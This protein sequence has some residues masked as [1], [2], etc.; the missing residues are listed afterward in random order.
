MKVVTAAEMRALDRATIERATP[1]LVLMERAGRGV[2]DAVL[3]RL[4]PPGGRRI[5]V[6]AGAGNNGGDGLVAARLLAEHGEHVTVYLATGRERLTP[7]A[8]T[9]LAAVCALGV[10]ARDLTTRDAL[11]EASARIA[12]ADAVVDAVFGTG[13]DRELTPHLREVV[14]AMNRC[15]G[16]R[17]AVDVPSGLHADT[18]EALG[19]VFEADL[20]VTFA[21]PKI[22]L[23]THPGFAHAGRVETVDIGI[24]ASLA[25]EQGVRLELLDEAAASA[26]IPPRPLSGHK[27]AFGHILVV[28][29]SKGRTGAALLAGEGALRGG[30]GLCTIASTPAGQQALSA[31]VVEAMTATYCDD[32][33]PLAG[34]LAR[35]LEL[36]AAKEALVVGP[37]IPRGEGMRELVAGLVRESPAPLVLDADAL[38]L[39]VGRTGV[40]RQAR[41]PVALTPHPGEMARLVGRT[42]A[43]V[44]SDR[45]GVARRLAAETGATVALKGARTIIACADGRAWIC[46]TGNPGMASGGTGDVLAGLAGALVGQGVPMPGALCAAVYIHGAAGDRAALRRGFAGLIARDLLDEIPSVLRD[47]Q[48]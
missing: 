8:R 19:A 13:L 22:G 30:A 26:L 38:N 44:Q 42:V 7:D 41:V 37:G 34:D 23:V 17:I 40:L 31:H 36:A 27:G 25:E 43:E 48:R 45:V 20:T 28:A 1:S 6:V 47:W 18:G 21:F 15:C 4:G 35:L 5:A 29:G 10:D 12:A 46:P 11:S 33:E 24:P 9:N 39:L 16:A 14:E 3:V 32:E 2:A